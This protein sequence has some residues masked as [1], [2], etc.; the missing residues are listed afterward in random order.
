MI[1]SCSSEPLFSADLGLSE[2]LYQEGSAY[3][4]TIVLIWNGYI[5]M[6]P[7]HI[8]MTGARIGPFESKLLEPPDKLFPGDWNEPRQLPSA[9]WRL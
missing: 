8:G 7:D 3:L 1:I 9:P 4:L 6:F 2:N 5:Q